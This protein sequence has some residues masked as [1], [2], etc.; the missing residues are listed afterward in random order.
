MIRRRPL[1]LA[2]TLCLALLTACQPQL[3]P[4]S[5]VQGE[6]PRS[7]LAGQ[8]VSVEGVVNA[9]FGAG[10]GGFFLQSDEAGLF[11]AWPEGVQP[12]P[13][14]GDRVRVRGTV[15]E[16]GQGEAT[17]TALIQPRVEILGHGEPPAPRVLD[18]PP[19]DWEPHEGVLIRIQAPLTV[20]GNYTLLRYGELEVAFDGRL[21][22]PTELAPPGPEAA[23]IAADNARRRLLLDDG[24]TLHYPDSLPYLPQPLSSEAP[25]R[26]GSLVRG[27]TGVLDHRFGRYRLQLTAPLDIEQAPRPDAPRVAGALRIAA[28]NLENLFNGDGRGGGFPTARGAATPEEHARQV[29][30]LVAAVQGLDPDLAALSEVE[31][32]G[33]GPDSALAQFVDALNA[34]GPAHDW[35]YIASGEFAGGDAIRVAL[36]YR[37]GR[38]TPVG[39]VAGLTAAPFDRGNRPPLAAAFRQGDAAP[40]VVVANHFKSKGGCPP[41]PDPNADQGD[42]QACWNALRTRAA[43]ALHAWIAS[44]PTQIGSDRAVILGDLNSYSQEDPLRTLRD[45][46][47]VDAFANGPSYSYVFAGQAGRLDHA[48]LSPALAPR[49]RGA[50]KWH[51]NADEHEGFGYPRCP[52]LGCDGPWASSDHDPV[53][54]GLDP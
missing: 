28:F 8:T 35:R 16:L 15:A 11:V 7:P 36:I 43:K 6:G 34:A 9:E 24:R 45:L 20:T 13:R 26:A 40:I 14:P 44:D 5:A 25:L 37:E 39:R 51:I 46:G 18:T 21:W 2:A 33:D 47:W 42:G 38:V 49:L 29:A 50:A 12:V 4:L 10:L 1:P 19:A 53:L 31:N 22:T 48:L 54:I 32:D 27:A 17:V 52:A 23:R 30:K 3:T 41:G